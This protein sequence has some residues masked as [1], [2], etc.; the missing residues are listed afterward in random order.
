[1]SKK[2]DTSRE[3]RITRD[4]VMRE[5]FSMNY[6]SPLDIVERIRED[7]MNYRWARR[8]TQ[9]QDDFRIEELS[10]QGW[11][12]VP[13]SKAP[14]FT[15]D[16]LNRNPLSKEFITYKDVLLMQRPSKYS[17]YERDQLR[18]RNRDQI[19]NLRGVSDDYATPRFSAIR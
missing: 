11:T 8:T 10:L 7:G 19:R 9:G 15:A 1:M 16:P 12:P 3:E 17:D 6:T 5:E 14:R 13:A 18:L 4:D 2:A